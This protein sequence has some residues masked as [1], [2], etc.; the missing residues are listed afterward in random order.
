MANRPAPA[1]VLREEADREKLERLTRASSVRAGVAQ[2]ARIVLLA[3]EGM[4]NTAIAE[5]VG[6]SRPTV[7]GWRER[8]QAR[9]IAG[10]DDEQRSGRPRSIDHAAIVAATLKPPPAK[11]GV[12]HWSTRL[13]AGRLGISD[14]T[15]AKAWR[16]YGVQPWRSQSFRFST[17]PQLVAKVVDVVGL[18]LSPPQNAVVLS[19]DEK[20]QIQALE[21]STPI[22][23]LQPGLAQRRSHDYI[24]HGTST[25]FAALE[26]STGKVTAALKARHRHQEFLAFLKQVARAYPDQDLHLVM[27]NYAAHKH[28]TVQDWLAANPRVRCHFTPTHASWMNLVEVWFSLAERQAIH[29]GSYRS[30]R[31]LNAKIRAYIDGWNDRAHPFVW[32]KTADEILKKA[33]RKNTSNAR[34]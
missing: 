24:R 32:T 17:D 34:H 11:L 25:L 30:V 26:I 6:M 16:D 5:L 9:G 2:R 12:S 21:R 31:D 18:Y 27:D 13:L 14:A 33:N 23:P 4:S 7:I 22:L 1:L 15:V 8:Y 28:K 10:L 3:A 19:V 20:S 29:R